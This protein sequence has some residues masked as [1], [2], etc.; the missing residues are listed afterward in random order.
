MSEINI[1]IYVLLFFLNKI[2]F[3]FYFYTFE[4]S[5]FIY[6]VF[7]CSKQPTLRDTFQPLYVLIKRHYV[8]SVF[9]T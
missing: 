9:V 6:Q 8:W 7:L 4:T 2:V 5:N 3:A 1:H